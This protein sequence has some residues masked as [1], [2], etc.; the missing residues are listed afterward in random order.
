MSEFFSL[1]GITSFGTMICG[2]IPDVYTSIADM[3]GWMREKVCGDDSADL[4][5]WCS[6]SHTPDKAASSG[7][8]AAAADDDD[9]E[10]KDQ[11]ND[12]DQKKDKKNKDK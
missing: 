6:G 10:D 8:P 5:S 3:I 2:L 4:P 7:S 1:V 12:K 11:K 9:G